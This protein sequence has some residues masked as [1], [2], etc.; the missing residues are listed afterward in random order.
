MNSF[1]MKISLYKAEFEL[2]IAILNSSETEEMAVRNS[3][4]EVTSKLIVCTSIST[5]LAE[6]WLLDAIVVVGTCTD[7]Y[8]IF[9]EHL[10]SALNILVAD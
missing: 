3:Y 4:C 8:C 2:W 1:S 6:C 9:L 10:S 7:T 5:L